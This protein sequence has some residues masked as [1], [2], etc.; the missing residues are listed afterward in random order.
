MATQETPGGPSVGYI[1]NGFPAPGLRRTVRHITGHN[2]NG[3]SV[4][5]SADSGDHHKIMGDQQAI[6]NILYSTIETPVDL[7][8]DVDIKHAKEN[9]PPLNYTNGTVV[10]MVDFGPGVGTPLHRAMSI[11]YGAVMEGEFELTLDSGE[12]RVLRQGD[13]SINRAG[14]HAW[15]NLTGNGNLPGRMLYVL[16]GSKDVVVNGEKLGAYL[17]WLEKYHTGE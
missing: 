3:K 9:E 16:V 7:N 1:T 14:A 17:G 5:L 11:V 2:D 13:V 4:F 12:T 15:R 8:D 6:A 10:R